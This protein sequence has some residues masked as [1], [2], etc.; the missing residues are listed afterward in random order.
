MTVFLIS[1][2]SCDISSKYEKR[3]KEKIQDYL[4]NNRNLNFSLKPSGLYY[5]E[6]EAGT[7]L[8]PI[9]GDS[10][11]V[12]YTGLFLSG[13]IFDSNAYGTDTYDYIVGNNRNVEG[14]NEGI[15]YM[16]EGGKALILI[17][18]SLGWG[19]IGSYPYIEGYTPVLYQLELVH[20]KRP[21]K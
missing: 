15:S 3:E 2:A 7:G 19:A 12:T 10:V 18:S 14:F 21:V 20:V 16:K 9:I 1:L 4:D 5:L 17:P 6:V 8:S 13:N 11:F